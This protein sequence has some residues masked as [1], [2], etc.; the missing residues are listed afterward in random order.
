[1]KLKYPRKP[2]NKPLLCTDA[3]ESHG[4]GEKQRLEGSWLHC[5]HQ[6]PGRSC[7]KPHEMPQ[8]HRSLPEQEGLN[9]VFHPAMK[10]RGKKKKRQQLTLEHPEAK[11]LGRQSQPALPGHVL[12]LMHTCIRPCGCLKRRVRLT[13]GS[14]GFSLQ[15][16]TRQV[17][18]PSPA[19][20]AQRR[21]R[22]TVP[23]YSREKLDTQQLA[24]NIKTIPIVHSFLPSWQTL[25]FQLCM[26]TVP[27]IAFP[28][29]TCDSF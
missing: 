13:G 8:D 17:F 7:S 2:P 9:L 22:C 10:I 25:L 20:P 15:R 24:A 14:W 1:M 4:S 11:D 26:Q 23:G 6:E 18:L 5:D 21:Q 27:F 28:A 16:R 12:H 19:S 3:R 29:F